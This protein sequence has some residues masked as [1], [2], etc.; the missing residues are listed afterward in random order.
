MALDFEVDYAGAILDW[1]FEALTE[2][3]AKGVNLNTCTILLGRLEHDE[4]MSWLYSQHGGCCGVFQQQ[5]DFKTKQSTYFMHGVRVV[6]NLQNHSQIV[7]KET[8]I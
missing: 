6:F 3:H 7:I 4:I 1:C 8:G 5:Y 2:I